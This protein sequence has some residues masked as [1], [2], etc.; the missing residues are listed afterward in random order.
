MPKGSAAWLS[1][2]TPAKAAKRLAVIGLDCADPNLLEELLGGLPTFR[3]LIGGG[4]FS[5][6]ASVDPPITVPAWMCMF[7]GRDPGELGVYGFRNRAD[8][9]YGG[10]AVASSASFGVPAVWDELGRRGKRSIL[11]GVPGTYPP[12]PVRG[13]MVAGPLTPNGGTNFT[14]PASLKHRIATWVGDYIPDVRGFRTQDKGWLIERVRGMTEQRFSLA[15]RLLREER[16]DLFV[17]VEMGP[18]RIHHGLWAHH[19]PHH[20]KH[21]PKSPFRDAIR[22]Y[23]RFLDGKL[24]ELLSELPGGTQVLVVSDHGVQGMEGG[25]GINEWLIQEGYLV[26][27]R[28]PERPVRLGEL[29]EAGLVDWSRTVAW[30]EGGYYGR[31]FLNLAGR[32]PQGIVPPERYEEIRAE[33]AAR[34]AAIPDEAGRPIGT[35]V[36][37]PEG[38]YRKVRGIP[39]D[40]IVYFGDLGWRSIGTVGWRKVHLRE[41]DTGPDEANHS[42]HGIFIAYPKLDD[43]PERSILEVHDLILSV[44]GDG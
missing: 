23:Y 20:S 8:Y 1:G 41:N 31:V 36:L 6:L 38:L 37:R 35:R 13:L 10:L 34:L 43:R 21:D 26:L 42:H 33:L 19:D 24:A 32:E 11:L 7:T 30:G 4:T 17:M 18:D 29:V 27:R 3:E 22:D 44:M 9:S 40:L 39:P 5:R 28:Y 14:Y 25:I 16:W 2:T 15:R 12:R